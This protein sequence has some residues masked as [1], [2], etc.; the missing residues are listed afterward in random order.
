[1]LALAMTLAHC[2]P[3][4]ETGAPAPSRSGIAQT[5][6][7]PLDSILAQANALQ[8]SDAALGNLEARV[9]ALRARAAI[10]RRM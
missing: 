8:S 10:L 2:M 4:P 6:L 7:L 3:M 5:Q 9:A 1:M